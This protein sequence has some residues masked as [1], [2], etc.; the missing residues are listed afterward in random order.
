MFKNFVL[1][2]EYKINI[3]MLIPKSTVEMRFMFENGKLPVEFSIYDILNIIDKDNFKC[4]TF[5]YV[6]TENKMKQVLKYLV[7]TFKEYKDKIEEVSESSEKIGEIEKD[8]EDKK[9]SIIQT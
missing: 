8:T 7:D 2:L 9:I 5:G 1:K 3:S 6:A 4:Y